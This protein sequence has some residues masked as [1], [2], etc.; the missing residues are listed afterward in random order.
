MSAGMFMG[1]Y[2]FDGPAPVPEFLGA[3]NDYGRR[4]SRLVHA[5]AIVYGMTL[6]NLQRDLP[7]GEPPWGRGLV[8]AGALWSVLLAVLM[9]AGGVAHENASLA[10]GPVAV[11]LGV[12]ACLPSLL[13][14]AGRDAP[15]GGRA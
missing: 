9:T 11:G 13:G 15:P 14:R 1:L 6:L 10:V 4:I 12:A 3:Y 8:V 7:E 2:A 5:Y